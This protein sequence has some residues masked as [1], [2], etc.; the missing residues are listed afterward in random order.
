MQCAFKYFNRLHFKLASISGSPNHH[1]S[2]Y[3]NCLCYLRRLVHI[4]LLKIIQLA[5]TLTHAHTPP[6]SDQLQW[7]INSYLLAISFSL[8]TQNKLHIAVYTWSVSTLYW[9]IPC[10]T[11]YAMAYYCGGLFSI[12]N[13]SILFCIGPRVMRLI[14]SDIEL[15]YRREI[16]DGVMSNYLYH[17][18]A[19][20]PT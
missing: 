1:D 6:I 18:N 4:Q 7:A 3:Y 15:K 5:H 12:C 2:E 13:N 19:Q 17:C 9:L 8:P 11:H 16:G 14:R 20:N 10:F